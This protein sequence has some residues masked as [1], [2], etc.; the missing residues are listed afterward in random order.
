MF[1]TARE[2]IS[3]DSEAVYMLGS[4]P[5]PYKNT[6]DGCDCA[7]PQ[8]HSVVLADCENFLCQ[9]EGMYLEC[10]YMVMC[11][12]DLYVSGSC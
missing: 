4:I 6:L 11:E 9:R 10:F 7:I 3:P 12:A 2:V 1:V 5:R 8:S